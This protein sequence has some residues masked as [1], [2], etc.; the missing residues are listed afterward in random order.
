LEPLSGYL[1]VGSLLGADPDIGTAWNFGPD[2]EQHRTVAELA[3]LIVDA[4]GEGGWTA[5]PTTDSMHEAIVLRLA[6][7]KAQ[8]RLGWEPAWDFQETVAATVGWYRDSA[9]D[10]A[11]EVTR[12]QI[13]QYTAAATSRGLAWASQ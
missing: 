4:W 3:D 5:R 10:G 9:T 13:D 12:R 7:D 1:L 6:T 11:I 8:G 2:H